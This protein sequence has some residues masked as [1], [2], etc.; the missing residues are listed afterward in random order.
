MSHTHRIFNSSIAFERVVPVAGKPNRVRVHLKTCRS[1][2]SDVRTLSSAPDL[3]WLGFDKLHSSP[4]V[5]APSAQLQLDN[6]LG[7]V[8]QRELNHLD[9]HLHNRPVM[10][11]SMTPLWKMIFPQLGY[12][13]GQ[14]KSHNLL[15][16]PEIVQSV[17]FF[18]DS[19]LDL[20]NKSKNTP[21]KFF[22]RVVLMFQIFG[23]NI[24]KVTWRDYQK[25]V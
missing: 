21:P 9:N 18:S 13:R 7:I 20:W 25:V 8:Q 6:L 5:P 3:F 23:P 12:S 15:S 17:R 1:V 10:T 24:Q 4:F 19:C 14:A 11:G 2:S 22:P 16:Q